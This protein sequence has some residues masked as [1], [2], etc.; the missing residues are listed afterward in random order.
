[1]VAAMNSP[2]QAPQQIPLPVSAVILFVISQVLL[3]LGL[4]SEE[5]PTTI[6]Y[7]T[8]AMV[9]FAASLMIVLFALRRA[10]REKRRK[11]IWTSRLPQTKS[12]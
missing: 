5:R 10:A 9:L 7:C 8:A 2:N 4:D 11:D 6:P 12:Q 3:F 1:M